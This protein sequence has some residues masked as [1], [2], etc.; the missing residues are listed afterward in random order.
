VVSN[1]FFSAHGRGT[2][3][4]ASHYSICINE[5]DGL[6]KPPHFSPIKEFQMNHIFWGSVPF[7]VFI[8][9]PR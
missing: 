6:N 4:F 9:W 1:F 7:V 8:S 2:L 3:L 5:I